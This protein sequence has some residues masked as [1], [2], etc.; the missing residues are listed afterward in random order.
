[1][2][3]SHLLVLLIP[4]SLSVS[5]GAGHPPFDHG[6]PDTENNTFHYENL[7]N[8]K[9]SEDVKNLYTFGNEN[10]FDASYYIAFECNSQTAEKIIDANKM[11][12][13]SIKGAELRL[14][15]KMEWWDE[16]DIDTLDKH[17][18]SNA[19]NTYFRYFWYNEQ[20]NQGYFLDFDL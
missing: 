16:A 8:V 2:K 12:P 20:T 7:V 14:D 17:V 13:D 5:C 6:T 15:S 11:A 9:I 19:D 1:M 18:F 3:L 10:G 4:L